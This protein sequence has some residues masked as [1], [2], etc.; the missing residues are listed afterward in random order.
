MRLALTLSLMC[1]L[2]GCDDDSAP[3][4]MSTSDMAVAVDMTTTGPDLTPTVQT[5]LKVG[6]CVVACGNSTC[7]DAC[8]A[9]GTTSAMQKWHD[10]TDCGLAACL[11]GD[12]GTSVD[13]GAG[14]CASSSD[15]SMEC[16]ACIGAQIMAPACANQ[17]A[18][19]LSDS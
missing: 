6:Q 1:L 9:A 16:R 17:L 13:G 7:A 14:S 12:A 18:A 5:C 4:D 8:V 3:S 10:L 2:A 15:N 11:L 19:C